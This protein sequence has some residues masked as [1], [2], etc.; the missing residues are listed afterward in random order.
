MSTMVTALLCAAALGLAGGTA[1]AQ[2]AAAKPQAPAPADPPVDVL[3]TEYLELR[4]L[5]SMCPLA[6]AGAT[7]EAARDGRPLTITSANAA[8]L[9]RELEDRLA[10]LTRAIRRRGHAR[11]AA[12]YRATAE[13]GCEEWGLVSGPVLVEQDGFDLH[14]TQ[15]NVRHM[16]VVVESTV[17]LRHDMNTSVFITGRIDGD[18]LV[19][20]TG[21]RGGVTGT[22]DRRC[23]L[24]LAPEAVAGADWAD[25]FAG[26]AFAFHSY[27]EFAPMLADLEKS[28][29]LAPN[30]QLAAVQAYV[31]A[32][33]P[34]AEVRDGRR[35]VAAAET[36]R[37]L[38]GG[39]MDP[40]VHECLAVAHAEAGDFE[41]AVTHQ[42]RLIDLVPEEERP[43]LRERLR[44]FEAGRP[45]HETSAGP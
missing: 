37:R 36:A 14:L 41:A 29:A 32:T 44:L 3:V 19:F 13:G 16:G 40:M 22:A 2:P 1:H 23:T 42:R 20:V 6:A 45:F 35:A 25:A 31:L 9:T 7:I 21:E 28:Q 10:V 34:N 12:G 5:L 11:L 38:A 27:G 39:T 15:G 30:A 43:P 18:R 26:R 17:A 24:T 4:T 8:Q 33:C